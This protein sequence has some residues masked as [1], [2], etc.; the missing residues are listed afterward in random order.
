MISRP[1]CV[2]AL[3]VF[4]TAF[5]SPVRGQAT[6]QIDKSQDPSSKAAARQPSPDEQLQQA[7]NT[8]GN[9]RAALVRNLEAYLKEFPD[10]RQRP[11]IYRALVEASLQLK[12]DARAAGYAER[13]VAL[14][15]DDI[16]MTI[17]TI[18]LLERGGDETALRRA[19]NYATRVLEFVE[20]SSPGD[21]S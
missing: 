5:A 6:S 7:I 12:D 17:L 1:F 11:Q 8:S 10:S 16:S 21:K 15:P 18:Q 20:R 3:S 2:G 4:L 9:D 13:I 19:T 14:N